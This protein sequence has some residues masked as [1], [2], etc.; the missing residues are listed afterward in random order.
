MRWVKNFLSRQ[1]DKKAAGPSSDRREKSQSLFWGK[2]WDDNNTSYTA[3][4]ST[5][6][7]YTLTAKTSVLI[8]EKILAGDFKVGYQTPAM[9]YGENLILQINETRINSSENQ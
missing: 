3:T 1:V 2:V 4:L 9:A 8:A 6:N 7:G 5:L